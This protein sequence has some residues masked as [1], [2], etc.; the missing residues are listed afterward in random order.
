MEARAWQEEYEYPP[1]EEK[2]EDGLAVSEADYWEKYYN[3]LDFKYEWN[4]GYLEE[5]PVSDVKGSRLYQWFSKILECFF[6]SYPVGE[7]I[8]LDIGFRLALPNKTSIRKPDLAVIL[9]SN[10]VTAAPD[11]ATYSGI[12]DICIESLSHSSLK[13]ILRDTSQKKKEYE[14]IG[15]K[16]Y[17]ILDARGKETAFFRQNRVGKYVDI[18]P[19]GDVIRSDLLP[20]FR[21]RISD[22]YRQ[23]SLEEMAE[24]DVYKGYVLPFYQEA[25][26]LAEA[27][28]QNAERE[29]LR[30]EAEKQNAE[31]ERLRAEAEKQNAERERLRAEAEKQNAERERQRNRI[32]DLELASERHKA[33]RLATK[34]RALG[35]SP[36]DI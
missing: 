30:A 29:R 17:Y 6:S 14:G 18:I 9:N 36:E 28:K 11:D 25:K 2:S 21:F 16:E 7:I 27:E 15:V 26:S 32:L 3:H 4:N 23:P 13:Q 20:E 5:K 12:Y 19:A 31:R 34:L 35:I 22:L 33:E 10:A 8:N 1:E 24:D